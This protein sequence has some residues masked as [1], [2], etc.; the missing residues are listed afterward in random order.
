MKS[1]ITKGLSNVKHTNLWQ[2]FFL[3]CFYGLHVYKVLSA[4][5]SVSYLGQKPFTPGELHIQH[6]IAWV[7]MC[8]YYLKLEIKMKRK[9]K[10]EKATP[11]ISPLEVKFNFMVNSNNYYVL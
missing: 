4:P 10:R 8:R 7:R 3:L 9:R 2:P 6:Q 11:P 5:E 1:N